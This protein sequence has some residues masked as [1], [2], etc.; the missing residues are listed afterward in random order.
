LEEKPR[1]CA[2]SSTLRWPSPATMKRLVESDRARQGLP[3]AK[4]YKRL[5]RDRSWGNKASRIV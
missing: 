5:L 4:L 2:F 3:T 1:C